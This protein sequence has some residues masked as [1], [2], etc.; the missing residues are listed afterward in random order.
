[1]LSEQ[2]VGP[3]ARELFPNSTGSFLHIE[4]A[5]VA[6][7]VLAVLALPA[8]AMWSWR[9]ADYDLG[10]FYASGRTTT[11]EHGFGAALGGNRTVSLRNY[12]LVGVLD[13]DAVFRAG[14]IV[15]GLL[16]AAMIVAGMVVR[17]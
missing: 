8:L 14:A 11:A 12:Y 17:A 5:I 3:Y 2:V 6:F 4:P 13:G 1:V 9:R 7:L 15:C 10:D 16:L